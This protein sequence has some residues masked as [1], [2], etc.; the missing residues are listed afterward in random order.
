MSL[1]VT[2]EGYINLLKEEFYSKDWEEAVLCRK[3]CIKPEIEGLIFAFIFKGKKEMHVMDTI[4]NL[5]KQL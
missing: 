2:H 3:Q 5:S 4:N 1:L